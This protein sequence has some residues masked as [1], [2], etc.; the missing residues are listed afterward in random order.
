MEAS[1]IVNRDVLCSLLPSC[2]NSD[3]KKKKTALIVSLNVSEGA[4]TQNFMAPEIVENI[5]T[6]AVLLLLGEVHVSSHTPLMD[7]GVDSLSATELV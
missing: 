5:V 6:S 4:I 7:A 3:R 2:I 1:E